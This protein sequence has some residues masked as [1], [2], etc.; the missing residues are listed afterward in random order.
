MKRLLNTA[1]LLASCGCADHTLAVANGDNVSQ[2]DILNAVLQ[3]R[4]GMSA[5]VMLNHLIPVAS[6]GPFWKQVDEDTVVYYIGLGMNSHIRIKI[7]STGDVPPAGIGQPGGKVL[8]IGPIERMQRWA[9]KW[10][11]SNEIK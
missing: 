9:L 5:E 1:L 4:I 11:D 6:T 3:V 2:E 8:A 7:Q 10:E